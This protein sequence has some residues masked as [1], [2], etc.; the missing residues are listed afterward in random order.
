MYFDSKFVYVSWRFYGTPAG[1]GVGDRGSK[2]VVSSAG[3]CQHRHRRGKVAEDWL[4]VDWF[5][6]APQ[7]DQVYTDR[8]QQI[9]VNILRE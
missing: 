6:T 3:T 9:F 8:I 1:S 7:W 2:L 4:D 5:S